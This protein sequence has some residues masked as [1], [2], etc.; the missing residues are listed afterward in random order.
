[1]GEGITNVIPE[2]LRTYAIQMG[3]DVPVGVNQG[4]VAT[5]LDDLAYYNDI[6][7]HI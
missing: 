2:S 6:L 3:S 4:F 5:Q 7:A 1:M